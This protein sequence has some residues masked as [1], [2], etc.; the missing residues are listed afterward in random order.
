MERGFV[1]LEA[2][3]CIA[4]ELVDVLIGTFEHFEGP[5]E[6]PVVDACSHPYAI[7][8]FLVFEVI[9]VKDVYHVK[10]PRYEND[11]WYEG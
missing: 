11:G 1:L 5:S 9:G 10:L 6:I 4:I 3:S 7:R 8:A 2:V